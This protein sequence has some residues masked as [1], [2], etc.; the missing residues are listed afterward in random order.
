ML[1]QVRREAYR[2]LSAYPLELVEKL[3]HDEGADEAEEEEAGQAM[4]EAI[5]LEGYV[6]P[7]A[8]RDWQQ[9][10][11]TVSQLHLVR[12]WCESQ[13]ACSSA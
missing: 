7:L 9:G 5:D 6:R 12:W 1:R 4:I 3:E 13:L 2:A 11:P 10:G 8:G